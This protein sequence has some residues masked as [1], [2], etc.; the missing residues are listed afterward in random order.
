[1]NRIFLTRLI[2]LFTLTLSCTSYSMVCN[3]NLEK[4]APDERFV[5]NDNGSATDKLTNLTWSRCNG[6]QVWDGEKCTGESGL[7]TWGE[8]VIAATEFSLNGSDS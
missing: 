4:S 2:G 1:M 8:A 7:Y 6:G 3:G 5:V